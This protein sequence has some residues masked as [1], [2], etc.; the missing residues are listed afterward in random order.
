VTPKDWKTLTDYITARQA[1]LNLATWK[2][3]VEREPPIDENADATTW[4]ATHS[5]NAR[6]RFASE[7]RKGDP[8][9]QRIT[10]LH[11]LLHLHID[12]LYEASNSVMAEAE[13]PGRVMIAELLRTEYERV[14][15]RLAV[16][17]APCYPLIAW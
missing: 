6:M 11:E 9:Y 14:V 1:D 7:F 15:D 13:T 8:D 16:A 12:R 10:V 17:I 5:E 2:V 4:I 3:V